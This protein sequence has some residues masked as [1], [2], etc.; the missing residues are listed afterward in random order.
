MRRLVINLDN[1]LDEW[2]SGEINQNKTV[3]D[4]LYLYKG[5]ITTPE[6]LK[7][8]KDSYIVLTKYMKAHF[9]EYDKSFK[10]MDKLIQELE[11]RL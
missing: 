3:R 4:A 2:L 8:I 5:D 9:D 1:T 11:N 6:N 7:S 10:R